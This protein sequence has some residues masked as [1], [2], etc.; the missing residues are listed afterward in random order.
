MWQFHSFNHS[1]TARTSSSRSGYVLRQYGV[2]GP[3]LQRG[4][5]ELGLAVM[6]AGCSSP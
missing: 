5:A 1:A 6:V 4:R 2:S 3:G